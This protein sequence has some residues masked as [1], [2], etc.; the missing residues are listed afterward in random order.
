MHI[1]NERAAKYVPTHIENVMNCLTHG[2]PA[3]IA[4]YGLYHLLLE[5]Q[6]KIVERY[7]A[8]VYG[9]SLILLFT[10]STLYH[11][12]STMPVLRRYNFIL[13]KLDHAVIFVFIAA[14][15]TPWLM[16]TDVGVTN[17]LGRWSVAVVWFIALFGTTSFLYSQSHPQYL[18]LAMGWIVV[19]FVGPIMT[20]EVPLV[21]FL[22]LLYGGLF[23]C[24]GMISLNLDGIVPYV[25]FLNIINENSFAHAIWH[26]LSTVAAAF[27][28]H[29]I[30]V[31]LITYKNELRLEMSI[32]EFC[33][34][35]AEL[36]GW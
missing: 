23:Y 26:L 12:S 24:G 14:S 21:A 30:Y 5:T 2:I 9:M 20:S 19:L 16:L 36:I 6:D 22:E 10:I 7:I 1:M 34:P 3:I 33:R 27:H 35:F 15:Y 25:F 17:I 13:Q 29:S 18:L 28:Y 32:R 8:W 11:I 4:V 31:Y